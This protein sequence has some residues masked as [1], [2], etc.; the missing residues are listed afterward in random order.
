MKVKY[1]LTIFCGMLLCEALSAQTEEFRFKLYMESLSSGKKDTLELGVGP[2][3]Y[4]VHDCRYD[5]TLCPVYTSPFFDTA[6]HIG[7]FLVPG[8]KDPRHSFQDDKFRVECPIYAKKRIGLL[9]SDLVIVFPA[10]E[11]PVKV[12]WDMQQLQSSIVETP[13]LTNIDEGGRF[14]CFGRLPILLLF[15]SEKDTCLIDYFIEEEW[16]DSVSLYT[17]ITDSAGGEHPYIHFYIL[18]GWD[19]RWV[20]G[21]DDDWWNRISIEDDIKRQVPV[22]VS[23]NPIHDR[24]KIDSDIALKEWRVYSVSGKLILSGRGNDMEIDCQNWA[25]GIYVFRWENKNHETGFIKIIKA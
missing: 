7:A 10:K 2:N 20:F 8:V 12:S 13:I 17:Y 9:G 21:D 4:K 18:P 3:G 6:E 1:I 5:S 22:L 25:S 15:M 14:D 23:P 11:Q 16:F 19:R 24:F